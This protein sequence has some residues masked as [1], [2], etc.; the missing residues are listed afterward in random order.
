[1]KKIFKSIACQFRKIQINSRTRDYITLPNYW[2]YAN[3]VNNTSI[4]ISLI[5]LLS[6]IMSVVLLA[7]KFSVILVISQNSTISTHL[8]IHSEK[9]T[10]E[11][12]H[13]ENL[14]ISSWINNLA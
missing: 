9:F 3:D 8:F 2:N 6:Q 13:W 14:N 1:M 10:K 4:F 5:K 12:L 11:N 7:S